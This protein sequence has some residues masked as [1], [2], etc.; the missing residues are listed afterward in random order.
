LPSKQVARKPRQRK[1]KPDDPSPIRRATG[2]P[3]HGVAP[4]RPKAL[5]RSATEL[6]SGRFPAQ[7][8]VHWNYSVLGPG[9][10][11]GERG[12]PFDMGIEVVPSVW[13]SATALTRSGLKGVRSTY[14]IF[15]GR[16]VG[17]R[18]RSITAVGRIGKHHSQAIVEVVRRMGPGGRPSLPQCSMLVGPEAFGTHSPEGEGDRDGRCGA[19]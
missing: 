5:R 9:K 15:G 13:L 7:R 6:I 8:F 3:V 14:R 12:C 10:G 4:I 11:R 19:R 1:L 2:Q 18:G 16:I 17:Q